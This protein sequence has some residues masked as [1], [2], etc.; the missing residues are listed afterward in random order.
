MDNGY[1]RGHGQETAEDLRHRRQAPVGPL[2]GPL[3]LPG[4]VP[5]RPE[6]YGTVTD[7]NAWLTVEEAKILKGTWTPVTSTAMTVAELADRWLAS[8]PLKSN[9]SRSHDASTVRQYIKPVVGGRKVAEPTKVALQG[10]VDNWTAVE[11]LAPSG[12]HRVAS[13]RH[14]LFQYAVNDRLRLDNP[15]DDLNLPEVDQG[16]LFEVTLD[17]YARLAKALGPNDATF[18]WLGAETGLRWAECAG[19]TVGDIDPGAATL[20]VALQQDRDQQFSPTKNKTSGAIDLTEAMVKQLSEHLKRNGLVGAD[21]STVISSTANRHC[22]LHYSNWRNRVWVPACEQAGLAGLGFH[23]L[24]RNNT[25]ILHDEGTVVKVA[26]ERL[27]HKQSSTTLD[28]SPG[29]LA[30]ASGSRRAVSKRIREHLPSAEAP[31]VERAE[32]SP[33]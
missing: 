11:H 30:A 7:A 5:Q 21:P 22:P 8:N 10:L 6:P 13:T 12:V 26:Q 24:R 28:T 29:P 33:P 9:S 2:P 18:M 32:G 17:D 25:T 4:R 15:A 19:I 14:A 23:D 31:A 20:Q 1:P 27:R 3:L 16:E